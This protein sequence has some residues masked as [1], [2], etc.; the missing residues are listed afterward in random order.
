M[1]DDIAKFNQERWTALVH[2]D[3]LFSRPLLSLTPETARQV[4][5]EQGILGDVTG[6]DV[7]CLA[8]GGG[9]QSVAFALLEAKVTV[10]DLT[11]AQLDQDRQA[12]AHYGVD[13]NIVQCDMR[14][15]SAFADDS[16]DVVWHAYSINFVPNVEPVFGEVARVL[17]PGGLYR[18][19]CMNP[20][21]TDMD[22]RQY[23]WTGNGYV[24]RRRYV[25]GE[26]DFSDE[27]WEFQDAEGVVHRVKGPREFCHTLHTV[28]GGLAG[29]GF[30]ILG[31][32]EELTWD[33]DPEPG[34]WE[35]MKSVAPPWLTFWARYLPEVVG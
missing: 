1:L 21:Y 13:V 27:H 9:Q 3:I 11:P 32:W 15:L 7:L 28:I 17:R 2:S 12:A 8:S 23:Q 14:D 4:V 25:D 33:P 31:V 18:M 6:K 20:F 10:T 26:I 34:T 30:V 24:V 16:F 22:E 19:M 5:D 29:R 35:H